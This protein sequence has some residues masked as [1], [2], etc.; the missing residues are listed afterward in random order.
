[1]LAGGAVLGPE[2]T[3]L[4]CC[5]PRCLKHRLAA[6]GAVRGAEPQF[7]WESSVHGADS[8]GL[9]RFAQGLEV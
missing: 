8:S 3:L 4:I 1:M 2:T 6:H 7:L 5:C 9:L